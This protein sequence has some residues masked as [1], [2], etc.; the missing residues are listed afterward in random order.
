M[1]IKVILISL[2]LLVLNA[3]PAAVAQESA[4]VPFTIERFI[5]KYE[6]NSDGTYVVTIEVTQRLNSKSEV[7]EAGQLRLDYSTSLQSLEVLEAYTTRPD[8][9]RVPVPAHGIQTRLTPEAEAAPNFSDLMV[10]VVTFPDLKV[11]SAITY[12]TRTTQKKPL[13]EGHFSM[14]SVF[15]PLGVWKDAQVEINAPLDYPLYAEAIGMN[16][17]RLPDSE[18][19]AHWA[20]K[21][22]VEKPVEAEV[23]AVGLIDQSPR[24][25]V[26]SFPD[27]DALGKAYWKVA[28]DKAKVTPAVKALAAEITKGITDQRA[29]AKAIFEWVNQNIRYI[30][31]GFGHSAVVPH[32]SSAILTNRYGDCKDYV[33]ILQSLLAAQ[34]IESVPVIIRSDL[35]YWTPKVAALEAFNHVIIYIP[36]LDLYADATTPDAPFGVLPQSEVGKSAFL[37]GART[38]LVSIPPGKPGENQ[39][40]T[41]VEMKVQPDGGLKAISSSAFVGRIEL[42]FRPLFAD[43]SPGISSPMIAF[44]L[45]S[46]GYKGS[47]KFLSIDN[48][49]KSGERFEVKAEV[50]LMDLMKLPGPGKTAIPAGL[51]LGDLSG[52]DKLVALP[53]RKTTMLAGAL[54]VNEEYS[55]S[56]PQGIGIDE[57]PQ[58][59]EFENPAGS[60]RSSYRQEGNALRVKRALVILKDL[61]APQ[62]YAA[63]KELIAKSLNDAKAEVKYS[64]AVGYQLPQNSSLKRDA[65]L[66]VG[67]DTPFYELSLKG[68]KLSEKQAILLEKHLLAEPDDIRARLILI[69]YYGDKS[70]PAN[71]L[72]KLNHITW[73]IENHPELEENFSSWLFLDPDDEGF[74]VVKQL[75]LKQ[76]EKRGSDSRVLKNAASFF[77]GKDNEMAEKL[78]LQGQALEPDNYEW[79]ENLADLY[80]SNMDDKTAE[81]KKKATARALEQYEKAIDLTKKQRSQRKDMGRASLLPPAARTAFDAG[82]MA[83]AKAYATELL[84]EFAR[85][86]EGYGYGEAMHYGNIILGRV[87]LK[88]GNVEKAR[89][90]LLVAGQT[91][92]SPTLNTFGPDLELAIE[93]LAKGE[94]E[95]VVQYLHLCANFWEG[96]RERLNKWEAIIRKGGTPDFDQ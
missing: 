68:G 17:G 44:I 35:S 77:A 89:V 18:G 3:S 47:G 48:A 75:W 72:T 84:M 93:L 80:L 61:Y 96:E 73:L 55:L 14:A 70:S 29:Q 95:T 76:V 39:I 9:K 91:P 43:M 49:H 20:W 60:Y 5:S 53:E 2:I 25:A 79:A 90:H 65:A 94:K 52:L 33:V 45:E 34:G 21:T 64:P 16:G 51:S 30:Y 71:Y 28:E 15:I 31:I 56:F 50:E 92:G 10:K 40:N 22:T 88:E 19:R 26:S 59:V 62:E 24:L 23:S 37:A 66:I 63:L 46:R 82:E 6:V 81:E 87:A 11:G 67:N 74:E 42:L 57:I 4:K 8:G 78:L 38:G 83:K 69:T 32:D 86:K 27:Y 12:K 36:S 7:D 41:Q 85:D 1:K 13:L 54:S 58:N